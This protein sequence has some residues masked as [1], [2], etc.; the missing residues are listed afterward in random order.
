[1]DAQPRGCTHQRLYAVLCNA[2]GNATVQHH[3]LLADQ[4]EAGLT[5]DAPAL[6]RSELQQSLNQQGQPE[7]LYSRCCLA[8]GL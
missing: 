3:L 1:M 2:G 4:P 8:G 6:V 5:A 7:T